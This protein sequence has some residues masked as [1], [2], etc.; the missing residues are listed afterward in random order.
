V[1][2]VGF[3]VRIKIN[4]VLYKEEGFL[5]LPFYRVSFWW[6]KV[7]RATYHFH[8][9]FHSWLSEFIYIWYLSLRVPSLGIITKAMFV[10][11]LM[12]VALQWQDKRESLICLS[13]STSRNLLSRY[14]IIW[15]LFQVRV[16]CTVESYGTV[17]FASFWLLIGLCDVT[18]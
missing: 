16:K 3:T 5:F 4:F 14:N 6:S 11:D 12:H 10:G 13:R 18:L 17:T 9:L 7:T 2:L 1:H 15:L 8:S